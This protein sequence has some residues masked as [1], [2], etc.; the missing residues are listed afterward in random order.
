MIAYMERTQTYYASMGYPPYQWAHHDDVPFTAFAA[1][2]NEATLALITTAA[3]YQPDLEDQ[4]PG[5]TYNAAAKFFEVYT[6]PVSPRPDL[7]ISHLGYDRKH[8]SAE[9]PATFLP[10][11]QLEQAVTQRR[12]G[13]LAAQLIG[14]PTNRSQ[15]VTLEQDA[16]NALAAFRALNADVA[17][18]VP[19]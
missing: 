16:P 17:L 8:T 12:L 9:D 2:I 15:R 18:F 14:V 3:P 10:V 13:G 4:G 1:D 6:D 5:A 7:R 19:S 11:D